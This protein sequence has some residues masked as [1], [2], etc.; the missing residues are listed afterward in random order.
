[1]RER[2]TTCTCAHQK[3]RTKRTGKIYNNTRKKIQ[4]KRRHFCYR[5]R[6]LDKWEVCTFA[7]GFL[8]HFFFCSAFA[9]KRDAAG[10]TKRKQMNEHDSEREKRERDNEKKRQM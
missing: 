3:T 4:T 5:Q 10:T 2:K 6:Q 1:M 9:D 8:R 7:D